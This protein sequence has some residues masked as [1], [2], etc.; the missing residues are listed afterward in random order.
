MTQATA[1]ELRLIEAVQSRPALWNKADEKYMDQGLKPRLW[2]KVAQEAQFP[3][4][5]A[6]DK[7]AAK[8]RWYAMIL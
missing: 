3:A 2:A 6:T 7:D 5:N 8:T 4:A 1:A